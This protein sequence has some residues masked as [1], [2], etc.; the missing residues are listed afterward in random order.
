M[1]LEGYDSLPSSVV[2]PDNTVFK[3]AP[4]HSNLICNPANSCLIMRSERATLRFA[5]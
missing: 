4:T 2:C 3:Q 1:Q 5:A